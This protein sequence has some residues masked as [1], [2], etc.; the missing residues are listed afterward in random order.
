[1]PTK[2]FQKYSDRK[3]KKG[4]SRK[5]T[6][7]G[8]VIMKVQDILSQNPGNIDRVNPGQEIRG[9]FSI[10]KNEPLPQKTP[11]LSLKKNTKSDLERIEK[12]SRSIED[13]IN[14]LGVE[15]KFHIHKETNKIQVDV[16]DPVKNKI[17]RK[18][19][20]DELLKLAASIEKMVGVFMDV[21]A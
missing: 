13:Y 7:K 19:P 2:V 1:M 18:I 3:N 20:P 11:E 6:I 12:L 14:S 8:E 4:E 21:S 15:L 17:I 9:S 16:I 5:R 10:Q